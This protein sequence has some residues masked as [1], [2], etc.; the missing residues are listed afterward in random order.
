MFKCCYGTF[1]DARN[2]LVCSLLAIGGLF[3]QANAWAAPLDVTLNVQAPNGTAVTDYRWL[4]EENA[5]IPITPGVIDPNGRAYTFHRS[6]MP[7]I[8]KGTTTGSATTIITLPDDTKRYFISVLPSSN[9]TIGGALIDAGQTSVSVTVNSLPIPTAQISIFAFEDNYPINNTPDLPQEQ[10]L[11]G[12]T[13]IL[14]EIAGQVSQDAFGN[15]L[16]TEYALDGSVDANGNPVVTR[17]GTGV[18]TTMTAADV[19]DPVKNPYGLKVGEALIKYINPG[20]F[21]IRVNP[22]SGQGWQQTSTIEGTPGV[23]AWVKANEPRRLIEFGPALHHTFFGFVRPFNSIPAP[24]AGAAVS[25]VSGKIVN[26]HFSRPPQ[27]T[28]YPGHALPNC[29]IGLNELS[30]GLGRGVYAQACNADSS[31]TIPDVPPGTYQLVV[32]DKY[33]DNIF[34]FQ[35]VNV[36]AAGGAINLGDVL[37]PRWFGAHEH[38]VF[39][40]T[41]GN[42]IRDA[43]EQGIPDQVVNLRYRDGSIY[44]SFPTDTTGFVPFDEV[45]PFFNWLVAEVDY[46]RYKATGVTVTLDGG[47]P[48]NTA[49]VTGPGRGKLNPQVQADG[50][51]TRTQLEPAPVLLQASQTFAGMTDIFEWGKQVYGPG[52]N[53]GIAGIVHYSTTRAENDPRYAAA[54]TWEP[55]IPRVQINLYQDAGD[56][57]TIRDANNSG[58]IELADVDNYPFGWS[59]GGPMG[60]EDVKRNGPDLTNRPDQIFNAGD[61]IQTVA[62]DSWDDLLPT[63]CPGNPTDPLYLG[64]RCYDGV[65][66]WDQARN[67]VFDGGYIFLSYFPGGKS[68]GSAEVNGLP[69]ASY[70]VESVA[71]AGYEQQKEEDKNVDFGDSFTPS[72]LQLPPVCVGNMHVVPQELALFPGVTTSIYQTQTYPQSRPLCDRKQILLSNG[73]NAAV[74]FFMFTEVPVAGHIVGKLG[75]AMT[76]LAGDVAVFAR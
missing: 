33:L 40:D 43:G 59:T 37:V 6:Y 53:G 9:Y 63:Q 21:G 70:I 51:L 36:P 54:E 45:F 35:T 22:P 4:V 65:R 66:N 41:N 27:L 32:W 42:G 48:V 57:K 1:A 58:A 44:Q 19:N 62:T 75:I 24:A 2:F 30:V 49:D 73:K 18:I 52:E 20:K 39:Y 67:G 31:F 34:A 23:D 12:F 8:T 3:L 76:I 7:V 25:T 5:T 29:W 38:Y 61:A 46:T 64:G 11:G 68:S 47:G 16:G 69:A 56:G 74:D 17:M 26:S 55:G 28:T 72:P 13:I 50:Q 10:G 15:P 14:S 60:L 71:P